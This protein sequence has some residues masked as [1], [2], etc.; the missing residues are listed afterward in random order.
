[1]TCVLVGESFA[2][3]NVAEVSFAVA[4]DDL[5]SQSIMSGEAFYTAPLIS[6]SKL[7]IRSR[8][9]TWYLTGKALRY[10]VDRYKCPFV[11]YRCIHPRMPVRFLVRRMTLSLLLQEFV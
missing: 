11:R 9:G 6:S 10:S 3:K 4:A 2:K 5:G 1:M 7:A 8:C